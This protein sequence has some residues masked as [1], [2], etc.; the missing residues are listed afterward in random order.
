MVHFVSFCRPMI[1]T[2]DYRYCMVVSA[3]RTFYDQAINDA[4]E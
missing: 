4:C 2:A 1:I 3:D